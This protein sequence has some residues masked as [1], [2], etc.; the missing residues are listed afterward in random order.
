MG[1]FSWIMLAIILFVFLRQLPSHKLYVLTQDLQDAQTYFASLMEEGLISG[2]YAED[3]RKQLN[4]LQK[5][6]DELQQIMKGI[7][8][9][10]YRDFANIF[11]GV[12]SRCY[13]V[14]YDV[15]MFRNSI[16]RT[17]GYEKLR[18]DTYKM[19]ATPARGYSTDDSSSSSSS[20]ETLATATFS[21]APS[22]AT[23]SFGNPLSTTC[24][25]DAH[26]IPALRTRT[27]L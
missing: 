12:T 5:Q 27:A 9:F 14:R 23:A 18:F 11:R 7:W 17:G 25:P 15:E 16:R 24:D 22:N 13:K 26:R 6:T 20:S 8:P 19:R 3:Y 21:P 1:A 10:S 4:E 2:S